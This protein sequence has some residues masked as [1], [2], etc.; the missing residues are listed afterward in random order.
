MHGGQAMNLV[1]VVTMQGTRSCC[2]QWLDDV[3]A[4]MLKLQRPP[5][6]THGLKKTSA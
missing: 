4:A 3:G 6:D 1:G 5:L 2:W